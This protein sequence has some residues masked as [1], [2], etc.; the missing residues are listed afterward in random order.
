MKLLVRLGEGILSRDSNN[1]IL[2]LNRDD[3]EYGIDVLQ[4]Y[5]DTGFFEVAEFARV[6]KLN[7]KWSS[8]IYLIS[9]L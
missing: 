9:E 3:L 1:F 8:Y 2:E 7:Y 5:V 4:G 6:A